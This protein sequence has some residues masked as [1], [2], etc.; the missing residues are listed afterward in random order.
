MLTSASRARL[1]RRPATDADTAGMSDD[2]LPL[3]PSGAAATVRVRPEQRWALLVLLLAALLGGQV[4]AEGHSSGELPHARLSAEGRVV[5]VE[6]T[7]AADDAALIGT[8]VGH[9]PEGTMEDYV[10]GR[11]ERWPEDAEILAMSASAELRDYLLEHVAIDQ[12]GRSCAGEARPATDFLEDGAVLRFTCPQ[13]VT[14]AVVRIT[15]LHEEDPAYRTYSVDGTNQYA[16]HSPAAPEHAWDFTLA[17]QSADTPIVLWF[18][19]GLTLLMVVGACL[20]LRRRR[21][22][23]DGPLAD[24]PAPVRGHERVGTGAAP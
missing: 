24:D 8:L 4:P 13:E 18:G 20:G 19:L 16:I 22:R 23:A 2:L 6:V 11:F 14:E 7:M 1:F 5:S 10:A 21:R 3:G 9:F 17:R 15:I 12:D